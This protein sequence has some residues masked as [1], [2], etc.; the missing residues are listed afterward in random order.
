ES[1]KLEHILARFSRRMIQNGHCI[2]YQNKQYH[3]HN[4]SERVLLPTKTKVLIIQTLENELYASYKDE[5]YK[6]IKIT[7]RE[8]KSRTID[9]TIKPKLKITK[10]PPQTHPWKKAS[11]ERYLRK[12]KMKES[13]TK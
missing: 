10:L 9:Y 7:L 3:L 8:E 6:L 13:T 4:E 5:L 1:T 2:K 11:Y 12:K